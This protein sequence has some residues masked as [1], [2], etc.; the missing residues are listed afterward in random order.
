MFWWLWIVLASL[1]TL[2]HLIWHMVISFG[3]MRL[4]SCPW[5]ASPMNEAQNAIAGIGLRAKT[6][7]AVAV[8]LAGPPESPRPITRTELVL[9]SPGK[10]SLYQPYH[11]V[12]DLPWDRAV[13]AAGKA[14]RA[15]ETIAST[16]L[17]ALLA[18]LRARGFA[19]R[20]IGIVGAPERNLGAIGSPHIR[21]HAA[22]GVLF[23]KV[24]QA[25]ATANNVP[26]AAF[27]ERQIESIAIAQLG[28]SSGNLRARLAEFGHQLGRPW[29]ADEKA[30]AIAAW[31]ALHA[32]NA[33]RGNS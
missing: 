1:A 4:A 9:T 18:Q 10:P 21:A 28:L 3:V 29:R 26:C 25:G 20:S 14:E 32:T 15:L 16:A 6:G 13:L 8:V 11:E 27:P 33:A 19:I 7:R 24:L 12:M 23:R 22:E 31:L 30:S 2:I 5:A 17:G